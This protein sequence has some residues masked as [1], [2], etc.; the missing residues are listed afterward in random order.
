MEMMSIYRKRH[1]EAFLTHSKAISDLVMFSYNKCYNDTEYFEEYI[2]EHIVFP[3]VQ[4]VLYFVL[5][6]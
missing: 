2:N 6:V 5:S 1:K 4:L 3:I